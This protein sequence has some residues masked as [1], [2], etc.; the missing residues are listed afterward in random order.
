MVLISSES[1]YRCV[2]LQSVNPIMDLQFL[3]CFL[4]SLNA[5][6]KN[7][8]KKHYNATTNL[9]KPDLQ[10]CRL[11]SVLKTKYSLLLD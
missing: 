1:H 10:L 11:H 6:E 7:I 9:E 5:T 8:A 2:K 4:E 3:C